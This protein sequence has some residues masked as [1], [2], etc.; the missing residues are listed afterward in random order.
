MWWIGKFQEQIKE[1]YNLI[2]TPSKKLPNLCVF[3]RYRPCRTLSS[4]SGIQ[5]S[6]L[7][8]LLLSDQLQYFFFLELFTILCSY[9]DKYKLKHG[10]SLQFLLSGLSAERSLCNRVTQISEQHMMRNVCNWL[11]FAFSALFYARLCV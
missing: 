5:F 1:F 7:P 2:L 8:R 10:N 6:P 4:N 11:H 9:T 3:V